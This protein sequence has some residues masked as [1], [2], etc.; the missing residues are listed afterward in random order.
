MVISP[1]RLFTVKSLAQ[2]TK[3][4]AVSVHILLRVPPSARSERP[5]QILCSSTDEAN[6]THVRGDV[7]PFSPAHLRLLVKLEHDDDVVLTS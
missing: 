3:Q 7:S 4:I 6:K 2:S 1:L 5:A